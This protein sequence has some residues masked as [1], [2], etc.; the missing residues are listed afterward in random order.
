MY[1]QDQNSTAK[2][3]AESLSDGINI[4]PNP[5][6]NKLTIDYNLS[7]NTDV[8]FKILDATGRKIASHKLGSQ[9]AGIQSVTVGVSH[10]ANGMYICNL[11]IG[12]NILSRKIKKK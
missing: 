5:T 6:T 7:K 12:S 4:Y 2:I 9:S 1:I 3:D 11:N 10:L 8:H